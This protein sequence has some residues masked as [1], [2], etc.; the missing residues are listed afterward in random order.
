MRC[1]T[2]VRQTPSYRN[3][4]EWTGRAAHPARI[5]QRTATATRSTMRPRARAA[6]GQRAPTCIG[7]APSVGRAGNPA[8][9]M[10][11]NEQAS[12]SRIRCDTDV[13]EELLDSEAPSQQRRG[14][15][16]PRTTALD[17][18]A[19]GYMR[20][21]VRPAER[22]GRTTRDDHASVSP[23]ARQR[24]ERC[25]GERST[26]R[27]KKVSTLLIGRCARAGPKPRLTRAA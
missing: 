23:Q 20:P 9:V 27:R 11:A 21:D 25:N 8:T 4:P 22:Q 19:G 15:A 14:A 2:I 18:S 16:V 24:R 10:Q 3:M 6:R 13:S 1:L 17:L 5:P 12:E 7:R 26:E